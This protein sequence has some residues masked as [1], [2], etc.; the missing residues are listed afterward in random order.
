MKGNNELCLC[1]A[2]FCAAIQY[3]LNHAVFTQDHTVEVTAVD[4]DSTH[5]W[6]IKIMDEVNTEQSAAID[7]AATKEK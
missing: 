5:G 7:A 6:V 2:E 1:N 4:I 3:Y